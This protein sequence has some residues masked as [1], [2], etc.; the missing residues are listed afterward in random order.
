MKIDATN[1]FGESLQKRYTNEGEEF[2]IM[3][4]FFEFDELKAIL[5]PIAYDIEFN[6]LKYFWTLKY[7]VK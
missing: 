5:Y 6:K 1:D 3:K 2:L 7:K 4:N